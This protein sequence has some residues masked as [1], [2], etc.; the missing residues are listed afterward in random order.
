MR[1][2]DLIDQLKTYPPETEIFA[3]YAGVY[4]QPKVFT[5]TKVRLDPE[6]PKVVLDELVLG[7]KNDPNSHIGASQF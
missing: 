1:L 6:K 7:I 5:I 2:Q 4:F 3:D